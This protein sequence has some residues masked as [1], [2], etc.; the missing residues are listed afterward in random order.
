MKSLPVIPGSSN[1]SVPPDLGSETPSSH[2]VDSLSRMHQ[3]E[4]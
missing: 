2:K 4:E 3:P 1:D